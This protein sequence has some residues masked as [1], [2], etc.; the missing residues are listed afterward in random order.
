VSHHNFFI[1]NLQCPQMFEVLTLS[2]TLPAGLLMCHH[3][4]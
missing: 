3:L 2:A 1:G 4:Q